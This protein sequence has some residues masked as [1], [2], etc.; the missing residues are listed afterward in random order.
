MP[1]VSPCSAWST[2]TPC[3]SVH[4]MG[5][6]APAYRVDDLLPLVRLGA[7]KLAADEQLHVGLRGRAGCGRVIRLNQGWHGQTAPPTSAQTVA[8]RRSPRR[9]AEPIA[10]QPRRPWANPGTGPTLHN[11]S[12]P[13]ASHT[14][15][16]VPCTWFFL[17]YDTRTAPDMLRMVWK[18]AEGDPTHRRARRPV[19]DCIVPRCRR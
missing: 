19:R 17:L 15:C 12:R 5:P 10:W 16:L 11:P 7:H 13:P 9:A 14:G 4:C 3:P 18:A 2:C 6:L 1:L 8:G